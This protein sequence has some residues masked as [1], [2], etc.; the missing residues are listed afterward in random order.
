MQNHLCTYLMSNALSFNEKLNLG[1]YVVYFPRQLVNEGRDNPTLLNN[2]IL[3][4]V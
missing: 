1:F 4:Y 3:I 2:D